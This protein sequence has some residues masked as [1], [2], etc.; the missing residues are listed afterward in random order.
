VDGLLDQDITDVTQWGRSLEAEQCVIGG[1]LCDNNAFDRIASIVRDSD[2]Y[3]TN[4][5]EIF[6]VISRM[7]SAGTPVDVLTLCDALQATP[8]QHDGDV[9]AYIGSM[10]LNTPSAAN[11]ER[12]AKMVAERAT[13]RALHA[14]LKSSLDALY[15]SQGRDVKEVLDQAQALVMGVR[16]AANVARG[17]FRDAKTLIVETMEFVDGQHE[18]HL[19]GTIEYVTGLPTGFVDVD[20]RTTGMQPGQ[21]IVLA[22]RPAMGKSALALNIA[23]NAARASG[24]RAVFFSLEMSNRELGLRMLAAA[25]RLNVQRLVTGRIYDDEWPRVARGSGEAMESQLVF[26]ELGGLSILELRSLARQARR[27]YGELSMLVIDYLQLMEGFSEE[28][29]RANQVAQI[30]RGLKLL[31]KELQIPVLVL[32]QLNRQVEQRGN[33][34]PQ[35]SDLRESGAIEQDADVVWFIYRDEVYNQA[36]TDKGFAEVITAKQRNG[37]TGIDRLRFRGDFTRFDN[38]TAVAE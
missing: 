16:D 28:A 37:P 9:F 6:R 20:T 18:K 4:H 19:A 23:E 25:S 31:A 5:R 38:D 27:E 36:S 30:S 24:K 7:L 32:S 26:C 17:I 2:F 34:R 35:L 3:V 8:L 12:Y 15:R 14:A 22:A 13:K 1:L 10:A 33:K 21:L 11:I 29:N